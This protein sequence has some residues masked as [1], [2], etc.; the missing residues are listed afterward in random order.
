MQNELHPRL[1]LMVVFFVGLFLF[2]GCSSTSQEP[3]QQQ[4]PVEDPAP[5]TQPKAKAPVDFAPGGLD[6][7]DSRGRPISRTFYFEY[8]KAVLSESDLSALELHAK[9]LRRNSGRSLVIEGH[10]DER[11]TREY[12]LALGEQRA[13]AVRSFLRSAGASSRQLETVSY[14]EEQPADPG[15][16]EGSWS[17]NRRAVLSYR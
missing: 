17:R 1:R 14:G 2:V 16:N 9:I 15:H 6:P 3:V 5:P 4:E 11:G 8:D 7:I 12:N 10:C 13:N